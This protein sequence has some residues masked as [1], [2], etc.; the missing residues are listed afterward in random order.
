LLGAAGGYLGPTGR[1]G[2]SGDMSR[3][4]NSRRVEGQIHD[5]RHDLL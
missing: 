5:S 4:V 2:S 1:G 3:I